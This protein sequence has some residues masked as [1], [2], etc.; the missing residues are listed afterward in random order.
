MKKIIFTLVV[1]LLASPAWAE[2]L[3]ECSSPNDANGWVTVTYDSSDETELVRAFAIDISVGDATIIDIN[4]N[5]N[6][7][8]DVFPG[9]IEIDE[10]G[11]VTNPGTAV[12]PGG[13]PE[14]CSGD[15]NCRTI[16]MG[17]LYVGEGNAPATSGVLLAFQ[18]DGNCDIV[19]TGNV[20]RGTVVLENVS[21]ADINAPGCT[22][23][24]LDCYEG[25]NP[26]QWALQGKPKAWCCDGQQLG[27]SSSTT[28]GQSDGACN[29]LDLFAVKRAWGKNFATGPW[30]TANGEY[31]CAAD[32]NHDGYVNVLDLFV[33]KQNWGQTVGTGCTD[34]G[35]CPSGP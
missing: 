5:L 18:V 26:T 22:V 14:S 21:V 1:L 19:I 15:P 16:E 4:D 25:P 29:V 12:A 7:D 31:N 33:V 17:S 6:D 27:D 3:I 34:A 2:V 35:D 28:P 8:Y 30:G 11:I 32:H 9:T 13:D 24:Y 10:N 23:D 20:I